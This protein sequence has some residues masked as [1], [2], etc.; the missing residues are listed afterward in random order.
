M[1]AV[2]SGAFEL[3]GT[4]DGA[5]G[6]A[7]GLECVLPAAGGCAEF[8]LGL[9]DF[10]ALELAA[11][12]F[13]TEFTVLAVE[14]VECAL[15]LAGCVFDALAVVAA[16]FTGV[17]AEFDGDAGCVFAPAGFAMEVEFATFV[18]GRASATEVRTTS[19]GA[20]A[21]AC[22]A[23]TI[24]GAGAC[25]GVVAAA[26]TGATLLATGTTAGAALDTM[27]AGAGLDVTLTGADADTAAAERACALAAACARV[28]ALAG[29]LLLSSSSGGKFGKVLSGT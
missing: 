27:L 6:T 1:L 23:A 22:A 11:G 13:D 19:T 12:V 2:F 9:L 25:G 28:A 15:A 10:D 18:A 4:V 16:F 17:D 24:A 3:F 29:V 20:A 8:D 7:A 26:G 5:A 14:L 21:D